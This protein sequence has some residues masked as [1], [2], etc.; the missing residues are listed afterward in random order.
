MYDDDYDNNNIISHAL[1]TLVSYEEKSIFLDIIQKK[2]LGKKN[3]EDKNIRLESRELLGMGPIKPESNKKNDHEKDRTLQE[4]TSVSDFSNDLPKYDSFCDIETKAKDNSDPQKGET[5]NYS[6][7]ST[8]GK[9]SCFKNNYTKENLQSNEGNKKYLQF[10][11][12]DIESNKR[13]SKGKSRFSELL[14]IK[15]ENANDF[16]GN[17]RRNSV[18]T[19][20][21]EP[22]TGRSRFTNMGGNF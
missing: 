8:P 7:N 12:K 2:R 13:N 10:N 11:Q 6:Q 15:V 3:L 20:K 5:L 19:I 1:N 16:P 17:N 9:L 14:K 21:E 18:Y 22:E 4:I